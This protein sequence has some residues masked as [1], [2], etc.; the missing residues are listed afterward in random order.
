MATSICP[1]QK[2]ATGP[3]ERGPNVSYDLL[4]Y[5][6]TEYLEDAASTVAS[7]SLTCRSMAAMLRYIKYRSVCVNLRCRSGENTGVYNDVSSPAE[8]LT[9]VFR[10]DPQVIQFVKV[11]WIGQQSTSDL[12]LF[13]YR[14]EAIPERRALCYILTRP[15]PLLRSLTLFAGRRRKKDGEDVTMATARPLPQTLVNA[16]NS[17]F[18][19]STLSKVS[20]SFEKSIPI[21]SL[22]SL[23][24]IDTLAIS[25]EL[26][27]DMPHVTG[28][29]G[30]TCRPCTL[31]IEDEGALT[32]L[33]TKYSPLFDFG[34]VTTLIIRH[35]GP[36]DMLTTGIS[37]RRFPAVITLKI[38]SE[39]LEQWF[40]PWTPLG[41]SEFRTM[42][43]LTLCFD[44]PM[45]GVLARNHFSTLISLLSPRSQPVQV[46]SIT[47]LL[48]EPFLLQSWN[49][50][51][52]SNSL[53]SHLRIRDWIYSYD[54][55]TWKSLQ[56]IFVAS[57]T[58][59]KR[60][61]WPNLERICIG[62]YSP[63]IEDHTK[64]FFRDALSNR[65]KG[66]V[67]SGLLQI[68]VERSAKPFREQELWLA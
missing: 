47:L 45:P 21:S 39:E 1:A 46:E 9:Q 37:A 32:V 30:Q 52:N 31:C 2:V 68:E 6:A 11:L 56:D 43:S 40:R 8:R 38:F 23:H 18:A 24:S 66:L 36:R 12:S 14:P 44:R 65:L 3:F 4:Y 51:G 57:S 17:A 10:D 28:Q 29:P 26:F 7:L 33:R 67:K 22:R 35:P 16:L 50:T 53:E 41:L 60:E 55:T 64:I 54:Q 58:T 49:D 25:G 63:D 59:V 15:F 48:Y 61:I 62:Y 42:K 5:L 19:L 34:G 20:I 27:D 13:I